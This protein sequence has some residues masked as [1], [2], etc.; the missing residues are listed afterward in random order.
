MDRSSTIECN[1]NEKYKQ[2]SLDTEIVI[3][4]TQDNYGVTT[5]QD[6]ANHNAT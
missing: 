3:T 4:I 1:H 2:I 6:Y 5:S